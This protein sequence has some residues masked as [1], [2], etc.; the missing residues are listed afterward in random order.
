M[1]RENASN[2]VQDSSN[3]TELSLASINS[4]FSDLGMFNYEDNDEVYASS[5]LMN[6]VPH[7]PRLASTPLISVRK[8][9]SLSQ[10]D[11]LLSQKRSI[12]ASSSRAQFVYSSQ[13]QLSS[14]LGP[15]SSRSYSFNSSLKKGAAM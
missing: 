15:I 11:K 12:L 10:G 13:S 7:R 3:I 9:K 4:P 5:S 14:K 1:N 2:N 8:K 6:Q